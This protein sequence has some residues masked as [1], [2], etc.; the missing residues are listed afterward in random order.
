MGVPSASA[1]N[2]SLQVRG[3]DPVYKH[4]NFVDF[5]PTQI[6]LDY[7]KRE[8]AVQSFTKLL[9]QTSLD[10]VNQSW[11]HMT[12]ARRVRVIVRFKYPVSTQI[13][14]MFCWLLLY[15]WWQ[16]N[17]LTVLIV[18]AKF[19]PVEG[20]IEPAIWLG[21]GWQKRQETVHVPIRFVRS[22]PPAAWQL[23]YSM[24]QKLAKMSRR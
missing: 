24:R 19:C 9:L 6:N 3:E 7:N 12:Y 10:C 5:M 2:C 11:Q 14:P 8:W 4:K 22:E 17:N 18:L 21:F 23:A 16:F 1:E 13:L 15:S 20:W